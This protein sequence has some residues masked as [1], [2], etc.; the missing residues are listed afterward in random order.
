MA[1]AT[2]F[3]GMSISTPSARAPVIWCFFRSR[4]AQATGL[5]CTAV[6]VPLSTLR[7]AALQ[8]RGSASPTPGTWG[9][10][11]M[12]VGGRG[13]VTAQYAG[14][15]R[16]RSG[17]AGTAGCAGT[18]IQPVRG[19][20]RYADTAA[21]RYADTYG[22]RVHRVHGYAGYADMRVRRAHGHEGCAEGARLAGYVGY[23][24]DV[25][26]PSASGTTG[27][28]PGQPGCTRVHTCWPRH[29]G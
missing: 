18:R 16:A 19:Y 27:Y 7:G 11:G 28:T 1:R 10:R 6:R 12:R 22:T 29:H 14:Y 2:V 24:G 9:T 25:G 15:G 13:K 8:K 21:A 26:C 3:W 4:L 23:G 17:R 5:G 20:T